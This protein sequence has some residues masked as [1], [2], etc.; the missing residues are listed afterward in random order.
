M[1][2]TSVTVED[3]GYTNV[4]N[5]DGTTTSVSSVAGSVTNVEHGTIN[6]PYIGPTIYVQVS[7]PSSPITGS[8]WYDTSP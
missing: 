7:A 1:S 4:T 6:Q 5:D 8:I 2:T 3:S